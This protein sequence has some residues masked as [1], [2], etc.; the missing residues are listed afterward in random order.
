GWASAGSGE[1][2]F[3]ESGFAEI[4]YAEVARQSGS[5]SAAFFAAAAV[6][7][8]PAAF[9]VGN[10]RNAT[11]Q[12]LARAAKEAPPDSPRFVSSPTCLHP[13]SRY[14]LPTAPRTYGFSVSSSCTCSSSSTSKS[15]YSSL[16]FSSACRSP[17]AVPGWTGRVSDGG[18]VAIVSVC[19]M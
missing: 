6:E 8:P 10:Y 11:E 3:S 5:G 19:K 12:R 13:S 18:L 14:C 16:F 9:L 7:A 17:T 4:G 2:D 1:A 15:A